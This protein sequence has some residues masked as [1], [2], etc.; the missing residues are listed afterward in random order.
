M[1]NDEEEENAKR[2]NS[3]QRHIN[4]LSCS[5]QSVH[6]VTSTE[7][8]KVTPPPSPPFNSAVDSDLFVSKEGKNSTARR[9]EFAPLL[10]QN[11]EE[12]DMA[13]DQTDSRLAEGITDAHTDTQVAAGEEN[14]IDKSASIETLVVSDELADKRE[15]MLDK[16]RMMRLFE[17]AVEMS[18][19]WSIERMVRLHSTLEQLAFRHRMSWDRAGLLEV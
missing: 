13:V 9:L 4:E 3:D 19:E 12:H 7:E 14:A 11:E 16:Q 2:Q 15:V 6:V 1:E 18:E 5:P 17:E 10:P 8:P